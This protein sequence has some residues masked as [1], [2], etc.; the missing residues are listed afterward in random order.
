[1]TARFVVS[2]SN[3]FESQTIKTRGHRRIGIGAHSPPFQGRVAA[4]KENIAKPPQR[5][6]RGG[7]VSKNKPP[8]LRPRG[9]GPFFE[10]AQPP[11]LGKEGNVHD[12]NSFTPY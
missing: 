11:L 9:T 4:T 3:R 6:G 2:N 12:S 10:G 8:R 1:M 7:G 5:S